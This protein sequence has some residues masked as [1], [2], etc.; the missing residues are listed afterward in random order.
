MYD[1]ERSMQIVE[2]K[3][4]ISKIDQ[5][6]ALKKCVGL[7]MR[8]FD[9]FDNAMYLHP[10]NDPT[11][12]LGIQQVRNIWD[13]YTAHDSFVT[14]DGNRR[15]LDEVLDSKSLMKK[16]LNSC[17][18]P[19]P[20]SSSVEYFIDNNRSFVIKPDK[21]HGGRGIGI[22][23]YDTKRKI[24]TDHTGEPIYYLE[25]LYRHNA[26]LY[27]T[28]HFQYGMSLS[29]APHTLRIMVFTKQGMA[30]VVSAIVRYRHCLNA[31]DNFS[32]NFNAVAGLDGIRSA[33]SGPATMKSIDGP[34][35]PSN[36]PVYAGDISSICNYV[37]GL[38][39]KNITSEKGTFIGFDVIDGT[40]TWYVIEANHRP[41]FRILQVANRHGAK[42][43][44]EG[45][46]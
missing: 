4:G 37:V 25:R 3:I 41:G 38:C 32:L 46:L 6:K 8:P 31:A 39:A 9:Y 13:T 43:L 2:T 21:G 18:V 5:V 12:Y 14:L 16:W 11:E 30:T 33:R 40:N 7:G 27:I 17:F 24:Y 44:L 36:V 15:R 28:P 22:Y 19:T 20:Y 29:Y 10:D 35:L 45:I 23:L 34:P 42:E 26:E 1:I